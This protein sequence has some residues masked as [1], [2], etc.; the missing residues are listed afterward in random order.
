MNAIQ[1]KCERCGKLFDDNNMKSKRFC[2]KHCQNSHPLS[3]EQKSIISEKFKSSKRNQ[4]FKLLREEHIKYLNETECVCKKCGKHFVGD[5]RSYKGI[6]VTKLGLPTYCSSSC[7]HSRTLSDEQRKRL[8]EK[9]KS[10]DLVN[11]MKGK[12]PKNKGTLENGK[13]LE[14]VCPVCGK[15]FTYHR[16]KPKKFCSNDCWKKVSGGYREGSVTKYVHGTYEGYYYDSSWELTWIKWALKNSIVFN[17]NTQGFPY[18]YKG[19]EHLY[20][21]DFYIP[22]QDLYVEIKG[23]TDDLWE[24]KKAAFPYKLQVITRSEIK[25]YELI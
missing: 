3:L 11:P 22:S 16:Y 2:S 18:I 21:P 13:L 8:S 1:Y 17:R 15:H 12:E 20:Y 7:A 9:M 19:E 6:S 23:I 10:L 14:S 25:A 4:D 5:Y 24:A